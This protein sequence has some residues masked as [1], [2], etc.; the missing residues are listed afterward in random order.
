VRFEIP[1]RYRTI[2]QPAVR[3]ARWHLS[4]ILL[5]DPRQDIV[6]CPLFPQDKRRNADAM[7]RIRCDAPADPT[8]GDAAMAPLLRQL[9]AEYA[10]TGLPP[11][12]IHKSEPSER[13]QNALPGHRKGKAS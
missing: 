11:A 10:A 13:Q 8:P 5:V 9:M 6:L 2:R 4:R 12:Y 3:Y 1:S 7:R